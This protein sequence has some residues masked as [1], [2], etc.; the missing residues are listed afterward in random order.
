MSIKV[1]T[2]RVYTQFKPIKTVECLIVSSGRVVYAGSIDVCECV[3]RNTVCEEIDIRGVA[4]P[5]FVDAH[6]HMDA[7]GVN[8]NTID[9]RDVGSIDDVKKLLKIYG[10]KTIGGWIIGRGWSQERFAEKR[11]ITRC[12]IDESITEL[13]V[14]LVRVCGHLGT[15]NS[16]AIEL[17]KLTEVFRN[18][19]NMDAVDGIVKEEVL[20]YVWRKIDIDVDTYKRLLNDAQRHLL[21]YGITSVGFLSA[22]VNIVPILISM[23]LEDTLRV[24]IHLYL[25]GVYGSILKLAGF[26]RGFGDE[27][28]RFMGIKIFIDGSLGARTAL[29]TSPY[30]DDPDNYGVERMPGDLLARILSEARDN[31]IDVA[32]HAIGDK[33]LDIALSSIWETLS[34]NHTRIEHASIVRDDQLDRLRGLRVAIQPYFVISDFWI[35]DRV[36]AERARYVYRIRSLVDRDIAVGFSTDAP[37]EEVDPWKTI[38]A[39]VTRGAFDGI[40]LAR[41]TYSESVDVREALHLYTK[42]SS[43]V[44][45]RTDIG[46]LEPGCLA[47]IN[48]VDRDPLELDI[49]EI[50]RVRT[51]RTFVGG[52]ESLF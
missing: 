47:D 49:Q 11:L 21:R 52:M 39:A 42:G 34:N 29:L 18:N 38:Y 5:G 24:R 46:C 6:I 35:V 27:F 10:R 50:K 45:L 17:L 9:L 3:C 4:L 2:G 41:Y 44:L 40:E 23:N 26:R 25:D 15:V 13:P 19:P 51:L 20:E 16:K 33:A 31:D 43:R 32:L 48:V 12:D 36:G 22:P 37:V 28:L 1:F 14:L 7:L 8:L 30:S